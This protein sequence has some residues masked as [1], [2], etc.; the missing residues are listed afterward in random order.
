VFAIPVPQAHYR[1][2]GPAMLNDLTATPGKVRTTDTKAVCSQ[3]TPQFRNTT[4]KM[5]NEVYAAYGVEKNKG[6]CEGGCEVDHLIS[7]EI[8][9]ADDVANLWPQPSQPKPGF[10]E[11]D[12]LENWLHK[13]V[14]AGDMPLVKAQEGIANDWYA[15]YLE[16]EKEK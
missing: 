10:H 5:K 14:C 1:H 6:I 3:T 12:K 15:L 16:M 9:G 2:H 7:L 13:Q 8:G 4:E 11:K